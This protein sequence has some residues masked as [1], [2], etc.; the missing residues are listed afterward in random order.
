MRL[1]LLY[2]HCLMAVHKKLYRRFLDWVIKGPSSKSHYY[3][4]QLI[5]IYLTVANKC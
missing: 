5:D 2:R 4:Y 3:H 1:D